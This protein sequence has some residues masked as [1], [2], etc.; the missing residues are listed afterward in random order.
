VVDTQIKRPVPARCR[1][2]LFSIGL[3]SDHTPNSLYSPRYF[4]VWY[5]RVYAKV[6]GA[7]HSLISR[8]KS[9]KVEPAIQVTETQWAAELAIA[10]YG[11]DGFALTQG[12]QHG[13]REQTALAQRARRI[14]WPGEEH[15]AIHRIVQSGRARL[16]GE[17]GNEREP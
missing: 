14:G 1:A 5:Q 7:L 2:F 17:V 9:L 8:E 11:S 3:A 15:I 12:P 13:P 6:T 16:V 10:L 4:T